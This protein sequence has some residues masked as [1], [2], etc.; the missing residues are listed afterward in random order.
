[1][2]C[3]VAQETEISVT[4]LG[5]GVTQLRVNCTDKM[6]YEVEYSLNKGTSENF[7]IFQ[8]RRSPV[9]LPSCGSAPLFSS[10]LH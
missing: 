6:A 10:L 3:G 5:N 4:D 9:A 8:V 1:V 7:Y 2:G